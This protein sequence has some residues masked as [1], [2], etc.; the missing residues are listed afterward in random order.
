ME[1]HYSERSVGELRKTFESRKT[2]GVE[3]RKSQLRAL[4]RFLMEREDDI[5]QALKQDLG[6]PRV[7]AYRDEVGPLTNSLNLSLK[8]LDKWMASKKINMPMIAMPTTAEL[9]PEP[10]GLVLI[11]SSWNFPFV[12][13]LDP[14]IGAI[15]A[16]NTVV[17]KPS[18]ASPASSAFLAK[19]L[20]KYLDGEAIKVVEGGETVS[21]QLLD[22]KWDHIFFTGSQRVGRII[23]SAASK[24]LTPVTLEL[25]GK[26]PAV[27]DFM[28]SFRDREVSVRRMVNAKYGLS[29]GQACIAVDY[30][31]IEEKHASQM[32][33]LVKS[34]IKSYY[35]DKPSE[36]DSISR[37]VNRHHFDRLK[38]LLNDPA[39]QASIIHGGSL[40]E[41]RLYIEPTLILN[42]PL[43]SEVM[44]EEIFGPLLPIITLKKIEESINF[45]NSRPKPLAI[46]VFTKDEILKKRMVDETSSG[47]VTFNDASIHFLL[48][49]LPF[50]GVGESGF[51]SYHGKFSF[52]RFSHMKPVLKRNLL[53]ELSFGYPPWNSNKLKFLRSAFHFDY[54]R[55]LLLLLGFTTDKDNKDQVQ[56]LKST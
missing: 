43:D 2:R 42:P 9:V 26:C 54:F 16:G 30:L 51:G 8:C 11:F 45:I 7:E 4:Q 22:Y 35:G 24:H 15:A 33:D 18:E 55:L 20:P 47:S 25:G 46:Y 44:N 21:K 53:I 17:L 19:T 50:G 10:L 56:K 37:I 31:L 6:K 48:D 32:I 12:L 41:D 14:L 52:D 39:V 49:T 34:K 1:Q 38:R 27:F 5:F 40:D 13:S 29:G 23:M 36:T 28:S 3:W